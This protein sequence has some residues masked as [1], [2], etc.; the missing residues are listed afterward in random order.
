MLVIGI[1]T[2]EGNLVVQ[3]DVDGR[4]VTSYPFEKMEV[5]KVVAIPDGQRVLVTATLRSSPNGLVSQT[6]RVERCLAGPLFA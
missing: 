3:L 5:N 6:P 1:L 4:E 2:A